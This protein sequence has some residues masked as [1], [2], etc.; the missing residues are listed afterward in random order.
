MGGNYSKP[1]Q[2][3]P[4]AFNGGDASVYRS[5]IQAVEGLSGLRS[6]D[7]VGQ[8]N[9]TREVFA[10]DNPI[11]E[12]L[13]NM[14]RKPK[15]SVAIT[16]DSPQGSGKTRFVFQMLN[17]FAGSGYR[18]LFASLEEHPDSQL[19]IDKRNMY[20]NPANYGMIDVASEEEIRTMDDLIS[21]SQGYDVVFVDSGSKIHKFDLDQFRK[22]LDGKLLAVIY[23]RNQ[24]G[25]MKGG[26]S[27]QFDGDAVLKINKG[28]DYTE[29]VAYWDKNRYQSNPSIRYKIFK[30]EVINE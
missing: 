10:G 17:A 14:E 16:M 4:S 13:G 25:S 30:Q 18:S 6:M 12:F 22:A 26:S 19:F 8:S 20:I 28:S 5:E 7:Q 27:A 24:D 3:R 11:F 2:S 9:G 29:N 23:Q 1:Y 15:G 21:Q